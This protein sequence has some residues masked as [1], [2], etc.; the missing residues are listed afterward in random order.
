MA[1]QPIVSA[2]DTPKVTVS[3]LTKNPLV[4]PRRI[5]SMMENQFLADSLLRDGGN[6]PGGAVTFSESTP[7]FP[8]GEVGIV[9]EFGEYPLITSTEG[10][11]RAVFSVRRGF[12]ILIS[13][14]MRRRNQ[15]DRVNL[16]MMQGRNLMVRTFDGVFRSALLTNPNVPTQPATA[17]WNAVGAKIR[18][19]IAKAKYTVAQAEASD[20][21][22]DN[23]LGFEADTM[24]CSPATAELITYN[25]DFNKVYQDTLANESLI[26]RGKLPRKVMDLDVLVSR[27]WPDSQVWVGE[28]KTV[29]F[30]ADE[31][32]LMSTPLREDPDRET[33]RSN[34]SRISAVGIDQPKAGVII[35]G[36]Q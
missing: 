10:T 27:T 18:F 24:V 29:G 8:N 31:R 35:T 19:D 26:Y 3:T 13:E 11:Q 2:Q 15:M 32:A 22:D 20:V 5:I 7:L 25:E 14:D 1:L 30:I 23:F 9:E 16:Q 6:A 17:M 36:I 4:I 12:G 33:W 21:Q 28:R 34:T